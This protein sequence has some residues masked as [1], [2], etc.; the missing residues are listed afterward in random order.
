MQKKLKR[1]EFTLEDYIEASGGTNV[2]ADESEIYVVRADGSVVSG[3]NGN[4]FS[5][6][7][8]NSIQA[9][10]TVVVPMNFEIVAPIALWTSVTQIL[11]NTAIAVTAIN[12]M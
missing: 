3:I 7:S 10:D 6:S 9:G 2:R 12:S 1:N 5:R 8:S 11:Y 4:F